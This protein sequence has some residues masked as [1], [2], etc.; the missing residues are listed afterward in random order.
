MLWCLSFRPLPCCAARS[1]HTFD[2]AMS[3][4]FNGSNLLNVRFPSAMNFVPTML[5]GFVRWCTPELSKQR[6]CPEKLPSQCGKVFLRFLFL[7]TEDD[8]KSDFTQV[9]G[10]ESA[11]HLGW[12]G[13]RVPGHRGVFDLRASDIKNAFAAPFRTT[14]YQLHDPP[15]PTSWL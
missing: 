6:T 13:E 15:G 9:D 14:R 8:R 5:S 10:A 7:R 1:A 2:F 3:A 11:Y 12:V 4:L